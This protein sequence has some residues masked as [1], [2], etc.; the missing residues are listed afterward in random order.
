ML[1]LAIHELATNAVKHGVWSH[2][3]GAISVRWHLEDQGEET[4]LIRLIWSEHGA[5]PRPRTSRKGFGHV[6]LYESVPQALHGTANGEFCVE[7]FRWTI[8]FPKSEYL[9]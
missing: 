1:G 4:P 9:F 8:V 3:E 7:G 6:M 2:P 5:S